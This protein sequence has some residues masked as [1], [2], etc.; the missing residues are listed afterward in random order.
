M[1]ASYNIVPTEYGVLA[2]SLKCVKPATGSIT[3]CS[4]I[5]ILV[6]NDKRLT[7]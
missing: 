2:G 7:K 6:K 5:N 3:M 4:G 1:E